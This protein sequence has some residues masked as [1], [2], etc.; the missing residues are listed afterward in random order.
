T[1][2]SGSESTAS[3]SSIATAGTPTDPRA[4]DQSCIKPDRLT[5]RFPGV[6]GEGRRA[7]VIGSLR[8]SP[9]HARAEPKGDLSRIAAQLLGRSAS[10]CTTG[11]RLAPNG[12][13]ATP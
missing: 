9:L 2:S 8:V 4:S 10:G 13:E 3:G 6:A 5:Q 11:A 1:S 7:G 12:F